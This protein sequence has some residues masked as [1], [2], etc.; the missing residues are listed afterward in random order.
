MEVALFQDSSDDEFSVDEFESDSDDRDIIPPV[1]KKRNVLQY[2]SDSDENVSENLNSVSENLPLSNWQQVV[3]E[4]TT[5][6]PFDFT[7]GYKTC[8]PPINNLNETF[9][10]FSLFFTRDLIDNIVRKTIRIT[11]Y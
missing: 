2:S 8:D 1:K 7:A 4:D 11:Y 10:C 9:E 6:N 3:E 5:P